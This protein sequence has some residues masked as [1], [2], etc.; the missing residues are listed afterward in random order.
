LEKIV[1]VHIYQ[2]IMNELKLT[3]TLDEVNTLLDSLGSQPFRQVHQLIS[4][5]QTQATG[6]LQNEQ[7]GSAVEKDEN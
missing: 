6:Q 1:V 5:I 4:K 2:K 3:L 7:A